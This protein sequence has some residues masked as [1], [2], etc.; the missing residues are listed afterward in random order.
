MNLV[1][2][3]LS[4]LS[5]DEENGSV[6]RMLNV[7]A[8]FERIAKVVL[9]SADREISSRRKR[10]KATDQDAEINATAQQILTPEFQNR[11]LQSRGSQGPHQTTGSQTPLPGMPGGFNPEFSNNFDE[12]SESSTSQFHLHMCCS[13]IRLLFYFAHC[14][15]SDQ[16]L[17]D[18]LLEA[19][20]HSP[21]R[22]LLIFR[23]QVS[24]T[25]PTCSGDSHLRQQRTRCYRPA[26]QVCQTSL[27]ELRKARAL[28]T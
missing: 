10:K 12:V 22:S 21:S 28:V 3:F 9:D 17:Y 1:V 8:E 6:R 4:L 16:P 13:H 5:T 15:S 25:L 2:G 27:L 26:L 11:Q 20:F 14:K 18:T 23:M 7:C 19:N 24:T